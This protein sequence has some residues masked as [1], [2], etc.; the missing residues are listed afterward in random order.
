ML[1][2]VSVPDPDPASKDLPADE[3]PPAAAPDSPAS[4]A[5]I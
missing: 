5:E 3:D 1:A 4:V 2:P